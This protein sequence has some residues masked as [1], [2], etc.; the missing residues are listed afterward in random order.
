MPEGI[1]T[2]II[3]GGQAGL[4]TSYHLSRRGREHI[5]L[6]R[7]GR[8][9]EAWRSGRWDSFTLVTPNWTVRLPG[10][11]Y[12]GPDPNGFM[13]RD[14]IVATLERYAEQFHLPVTFDTRVSSVEPTTDA[15]GFRVRSNG[16]VWE[17]RNVVVATGTFQEPR[18]PPLS[19]ELSPHVTQLHTGQYRSPRAIPPGAV[20]VVG[21][22]QSGCQIAEELYQSGRTV[23]LSLGGTGRV[24][25]R[26]RGKDIVEW[27]FMS[28]FFDRTVDK[29]PSPE[30]RFAASPHVTG[31]DGGHTL[32]LHQFA[33]DGVVLL[34]HLKAVR[35]GRLFLASDMK[36]CLTK[37]DRF[38]AEILKMIDG[39]IQQQG[40]DAPPEQVPQRREGYEAKEIAEL[41]LNSAG[42]SA[43]IWATGYKFD[44][45]M[46]RTPVF[47][48]NGFPVQRRGVTAQPGLFFAG[49]GWLDTM[50]T[51]LLLGVGEQTEVI[52]KAIDTRARTPAKS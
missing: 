50:K 34:G 24:P 37:A 27:L 32:N 17:A 33:Q 4:S 43:V 11:E 20:L 44:F 35:G 15:P 29:L 52:A 30:A 49:V 2:V 39:V 42:I 38:E 14:E 21:S 36:E 8:V 12:R 13:P 19:A 3:G 10:A 25:R 7:A 1:E 41:D 51:G 16:S 31:R 46:V 28:G 23:Y 48:P 9:G 5:V 18:I 45:S 22:G 6:E 47:E 40:L 26:Y